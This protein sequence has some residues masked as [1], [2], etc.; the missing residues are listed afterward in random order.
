MEVALS[1]GTLVPGNGMPSLTTAEG[2]YRTTLL[3]GGT[4]LATIQ[5]PS[6]FDLKDVTAVA[7]LY[8]DQGN[9]I[10][11]GLALMSLLPKGGRAVAS[12]P[13]ASKPSKVAAKAVV[14]PAFSLLT[15]GSLP[16]N[17]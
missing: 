16:T 2:T 7:L 13:I 6:S 9:I 5:N 17:H 14:Y 15:L 8:D 3:G 4:V 11:G 10:G 1:A 12:V